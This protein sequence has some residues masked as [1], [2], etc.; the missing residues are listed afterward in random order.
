MAKKKIEVGDLVKVSKGEGIS[1]PFQ[2][3]V[4]KLYE[5]AALVEVDENCSPNPI[6]IL[7]LPNNFMIVRQSLCTAIDSSGKEL[8]A[9]KGAPKKE[10]AENSE[11]E[12]LD[13][14]AE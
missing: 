4:T 6:V 2:G 9:K 7:N 3:T 5:N 8:K 12:E 13:Q 14:K 10:A 1:V 11:S